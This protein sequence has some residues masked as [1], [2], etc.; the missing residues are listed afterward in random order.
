MIRTVLRLCTLVLLFSKVIFAQGDNLLVTSLNHRFYADQ[1]SG[2]DACAKIA[3]AWNQIPENGSGIVDATG[4]LGP[5]A[6]NSN[7]FS[8]IGT[9]YGELWICGVTFQ[10]TAS[11]VIPPYI[12]IK[13]CGMS[14][15]T[16]IG[17]V[18]AIAGFPSSPPTPVIQFG[19]S[20]P[21][22][23]ESTEYFTVDC[24]DQPNAIG[25]QNRS[26]QQSAHASGM[27]IKNCPN[28]GLDVETSGAQN[29]GPYFDNYIVIDSRC[30]NCDVE[31]NG[32]RFNLLGAPFRG[33]YGLSVVTSVALT[34]A[35]TIDTTPGNF[36]DLEIEGPV[37]G[38]MLGLNRGEVG[39]NLAG[40]HCH[41][42]KTCITIS[43]AHRLSTYDVNLTATATDSSTNIL[44]DQ[45]ARYTLTEPGEG[46]AIGWYFLD[47]GNPP[48]VC[49]SSQ[50]VTCVMGHAVTA[51][52]NVTAANGSKIVYRCSTQGILPVGALTTNTGDCG[53]AT[54]TGLRVR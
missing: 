10:T 21:S 39:I 20:S 11:W 40:T 46:N 52:G 29:S 4:F 13:G 49:S 5:Q 15:G 6:C 17:G 35:I 19:A 31:T 54:D 22:F 37:N 47:G 51:L 44:V 16:P 18:Q 45:I 2:I 12:K 53:G 43:N 28:V 50:N 38:V 41:N 42:S 14:I 32:A 8:G 30:T 3:T 9:K 25:I 23:G 7:P 26:G 1:Q 24:N 36:N 34:N 48:V 33:V 27:F